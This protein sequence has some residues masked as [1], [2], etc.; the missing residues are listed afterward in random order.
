MVRVCVCVFACTCVSP[1][2][3]HHQ[4]ELHGDGS[5]AQHA[6]RVLCHGDQRAPHQHVE[7]D[8]PGHHLRDQYEHT[9]GDT[10]SLQLLRRNTH[11]H[12]SH[13]HQRQKPTTCAVHWSPWLAHGNI[14]LLAAQIEGTDTP[15]ESDAV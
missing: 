15:E 6:V 14:S 11:T 3:Q 1:D 7:H 2:G 10:H 4:P 12:T 13:T 8:G 9:Q 5:E